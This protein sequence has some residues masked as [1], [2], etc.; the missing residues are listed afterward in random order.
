MATQGQ[1]SGFVEAAQNHLREGAGVGAAAF[2]ANYVLV[3]ILT[4]IDGL[5][6]SGQVDSW[7]LV[8]WV[9]YS[10]HNVKTELTGLGGSRSFNL[11]E[12]ATGAEGLT[13]TVPK[14]VYYL[15]P[16]V[17]LLAAGYV[18]YQRVD[19]SLDTE[20][21]AG[22]GATV[23]AGYVVLAA[24]GAF[25]F[26]QSASGGSAAPKMTT[27]IVIAGIAYPVV[28]GAVGAVAASES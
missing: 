1:S 19:V 28:L 2:V 15:V 17:V 20:G 3:Y 10:A 23:A 8:G 12:S 24:V 25:L 26:E 18:L 22:V 5:Q 11:L 14:L 7:K 9:F 16:V 21:A 4:A 13:S 27:A 6:T